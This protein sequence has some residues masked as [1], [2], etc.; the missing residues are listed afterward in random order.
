[1]SRL[2]GRA[3]PDIQANRIAVARSFAAERRVIVVLKGERT[4]IIFLDGRVWVNLT[5]SAKPWRR[6]QEPAIF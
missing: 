5:G 2:T 4:L 1:M 3:I 6:M